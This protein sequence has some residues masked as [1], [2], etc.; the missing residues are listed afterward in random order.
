MEYVWIHHYYP[1]NTDFEIFLKA[2][3]A[4]YVLLFVRV[5]MVY[6]SFYVSDRFIN[7]QSDY[8]KGSL[9]L[10]G[11]LLLATVFYR[12]IVV[13]YAL[14]R[15]YLVDEYEAIF[16]TERVVRAFLDVSFLNAAANGIRLYRHRI[17]MKEYELTL[18]KQK[19]EAELSLLKSQI[20]PHFL[21]NTLNN[22]Y[23]LALKKSDQTAPV[24]HKLSELMRFLLYESERKSISIADELKIIDDYIELETLRYSDRLKII[25]SKDVDDY[26]ANITPLL[27]L[28]LVENAFKHGA[29]ESRKEAFITI[30]VKLKNGDFY[31]AI[32]N[33][34]ELEEE[35]NE[36]GI[37]L[38]NV[39][40]QLE[41]VYKEYSF[42][43]NEE[44]NV[45]KVILQIK[46][47]TNAV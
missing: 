18:V 2:S 13:Y 36:K 43:L 4:E 24:V 21:F 44:K 9:I 16:V 11:T 29:S 14:P 6:F 46:L 15:I 40:R 3:A 27:L 23:G 19:A 37:G 45:F 20:N 28:P 25:I 39:K 47:T 30:D 26:S 35:K 33:S 12:V 42:N 10:I 5:P 32:S 8:L 7:K 1:N 38:K 22:I 17:K 34:I 31:F 41:L